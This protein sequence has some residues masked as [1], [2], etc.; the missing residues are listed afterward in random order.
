MTPYTRRSILDDVS[1]LSSR[2]REEDQRECYAIGRTPAYGLFVGFEESHLCYTLLDPA[3]NIP[4]AMTGVSR[5]YWPNSGMIWLLGTKGI[6]SNRYTFL[7]HSKQALSDMFDATG[8]SLFYNYTHSPNTLHHKWLRWVG[9]SFLRSV[10]LGPDN[11][12]FYEF[13]KLKA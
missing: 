6:E 11:E 2:L 13:A 1:F 4:V 7:R 8:Y 9:F 10:N 12:E 5:G 3:T